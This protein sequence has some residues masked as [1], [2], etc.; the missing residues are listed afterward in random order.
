[1]GKILLR[2]PN[3]KSLILRNDHFVQES[4]HIQ[5]YVKGAYYTES[6]RTFM[7]SFSKNLLIQVGKYSGEDP[8]NEDWTPSYYNESS[9]TFKQSLFKDL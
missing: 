3:K 6:L 8:N 7:L 5:N 4:L 9:K 1:M 2:D